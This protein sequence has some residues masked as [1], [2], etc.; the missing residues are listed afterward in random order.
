VA[1]GALTI[2]HVDAETGFSGG[3]VQ[4]FLLLEGLRRRG[5]RSVLFAPP[6]SR[7]EAEARARGIETVPVPMRADLDAA[8]LEA[9]AAGRAV[10]ASAVG[11]LGEAVAGGETGLLVPPQDPGALA[12]A[13]GALCADAELRR[14]LGAAGPA[15][16]AAGHHVDRMVSS[17]E[18]LYREA[19]AAEKR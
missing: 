8:A 10:V 3:E 18:A 2:A 17:Y 12:W 16:V 9:M 14:R 7:A 19:L 15:R 13:L 4:V 5:H 6:R 1:A 11:G